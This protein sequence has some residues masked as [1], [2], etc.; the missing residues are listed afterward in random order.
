MLIDVLGPRGL[1]AP[2]L[3]HGRHPV[4]MAAPFPSPETTSLQNH[5]ENTQLCIEEHLLTSSLSHHA[6]E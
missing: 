4:C 2:P 3:W 1:A 6:H 5:E